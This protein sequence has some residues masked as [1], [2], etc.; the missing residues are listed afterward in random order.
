MKQSRIVLEF[1][2]TRE[3]SLF[4]RQN[5][6]LQFQTTNLCRWLNVNLGVITAQQYGYKIRTSVT[7]QRLINGFQYLHEIP[8]LMHVSLE[9]WFVWQ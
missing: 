7:Q 5:T 2:L 3:F 8:A 9:A 4:F 1:L 6:L